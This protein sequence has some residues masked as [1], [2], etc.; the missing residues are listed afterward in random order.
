MGPLGDRCCQR[1]I[2]IA[3]VTYM[4]ISYEMNYESH[5]NVYGLLCL[6]LRGVAVPPNNVNPAE[7][8]RSYCFR[9]KAIT[10]DEP[11]MRRQPFTLSP[12]GRIMVFLVRNHTFLECRIEKLILRFSIQG[13]GDKSL[14][15]QLA[16][17]LLRVSHTFIL[18]PLQLGPRCEASNTCCRRGS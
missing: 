8:G 5:I 15:L 16:L 12:P 10:Q 7:C 3:G 18:F 4:D 9:A 1:T 17:Q 6:L 13:Q 11:L 14:R 2:Y